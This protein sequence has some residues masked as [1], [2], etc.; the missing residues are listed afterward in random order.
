MDSLLKAEIKGS[1]T[2]DEYAAFVES[3][4]PL[5]E[6]YSKNYSEYLAVK[7]TENVMALAQIEKQADSIQ[8]EMTDLQKNFIRKNPSSYISPSVLG[9]LSYEM[10]PD[11]LESM[12]NGLDSTIAALPQIK[13]LRNRLVVMKTVAVGQKAP[14]FT[15]NDT[16]GKPVTLSSM[17]GFRLLLIDFWAAWCNPCR[18][19]N[20]NVVKVYN[21]FHGKGFDVLGV[22]LDRKKEDWTK[23]IENDKLTW[24]HV[25]D[26][27]Y[28][29]NAAAKKYAVYSIPSN[30]LLDE[31]GKIIGKDL[32][33][34]DLYKKVS[35]ILNKKN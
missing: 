5:S 30:F 34:D 1:K 10:G 6:K 15:M 2:Q 12:I 25:S 9:S 16:V 31:T 32:R 33:G 20:P 23:A 19:E 17:R 11:E 21:Q 22:S 27:Q 7:K 28:W 18:Q 8:A 14:D 29:N 13:D 26:L 3:N 35:E 24:T 4:K